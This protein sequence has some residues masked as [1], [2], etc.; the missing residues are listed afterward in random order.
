MAHDNLEATINALEAR[1]HQH[2]SERQ[3]QDRMS[4][5]D[6]DKAA[7][8]VERDVDAV[9]GDRDDDR[10]NDLCSR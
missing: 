1:D 3:R 8:Q 4:E 9:D 5:H 6:A 2:D 7:D 10:R